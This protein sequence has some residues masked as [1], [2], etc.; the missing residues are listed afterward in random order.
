LNGS[1]AYAN[2]A[3]IRWNGVDGALLA[4][5]HGRNFSVPVQVPADARPDVYYLVALGRN[6]DGTVDGKVAT[7][8]QVTAPGN[9]LQAASS[10]AWARA[11]L[12]VSTAGRSGSQSLTV[13][14]G[15]GLLSVGLVSLFGAF[16]LMSVRR[17]ALAATR[18][19]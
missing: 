19:T 8:V 7:T 14:L 13:V 18:R 1:S 3:E 11:G 17:R 16:A 10:N 6:A 15:I 2:G 12:P 9:S 5:A 4:T